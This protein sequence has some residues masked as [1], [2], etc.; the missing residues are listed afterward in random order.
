VEEIGDEWREK[1]ENKKPDAMMRWSLGNRKRRF[2]SLVAG[3]TREK[4]RRQKQTRTQ[5]MTHHR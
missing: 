5:D 1:E 2:D 4:Y 3:P